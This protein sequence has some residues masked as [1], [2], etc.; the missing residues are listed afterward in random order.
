[1]RNKSISTNHCLDRGIDSAEATIIA[2]QRFQFFGTNSMRIIFLFVVW[3]IP[4]FQLIPRLRKNALIDAWKWIVP[5]KSFICLLLLS[6]LAYSI[7]VCEFR[8]YDASLRS[9]TAA[10]I[11]SAELSMKIRPQLG[12]F[13]FTAIDVTMVKHKASYNYGM[14]G[15]E[16]QLSV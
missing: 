14:E 6:T 13:R 4:N 11:A 2:W 9:A 5:R 15:K 12:L 1:M 10:F 16:E 3:R 8:I 7:Y